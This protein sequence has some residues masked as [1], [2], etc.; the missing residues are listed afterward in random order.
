MNVSP[1]T[2]LRS[3]V[4]LAATMLAGCSA[5]PAG[6]SATPTSHADRGRASW[7]SPEAAGE[8]LLYVGGGGTYGYVHV[9]SY[10]QGKLVGKLTG[11]DLPYGECV[12][13]SGDVWIV[14]N[15]PN[16]AIEYAHGGTTPIATL[17][18][19]GSNAYGCAVDPASGNLAVATDVGVAIFQGAQ[20]TSTT[21]SDW[22]VPSYCSYDDAG[23]L[24]VIVSNY[25]LTELPRGSGN[26]AIVRLNK[27][28]SALRSVQWDGKYLAVGG[29]GGTGKYASPVP[30][31]QLS[32]SGSRAKLVRTIH[33]TV[34][35]QAPEYAEFWIQG[36]TIVQPVRRGKGIAI[37]AYPAG[38]KPIKLISTWGRLRRD[39]FG[40]A[41][42]A[43]PS[44]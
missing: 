8:D 41:V 23:N 34:P 6:G 20:G 21:Y 16:Q 22:G 27:G 2:R 7:M 38:G 13:A 37:W 44:L 25:Q 42:S 36:Q 31:Y 33:L 35:R 12:D 24:F 30:V 4:F 3:S 32:V 17:S 26:F 5:L 39:T 11:L 18:V 28:A 9:Y 43:A 15:F 14:T 29:V 10:P 1:F 40:T 19:P